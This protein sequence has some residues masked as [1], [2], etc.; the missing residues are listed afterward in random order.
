LQASFLSVFLLP[1]AL[2]FIMMGL[3]LSLVVDDLKRVVVSPKAVLVG[4]AC[5]VVVLPLACYAWCWHGAWSP[6]W[7]WA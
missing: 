1:V 4:L 2:A 5:Q 6:C 7:R 3:G